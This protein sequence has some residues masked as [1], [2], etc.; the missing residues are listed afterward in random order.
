MSRLKDV[1]TPRLQNFIEFQKDPLFSFLNML[2]KGDIVS[3]RT[4]FKP[5]FIVN[6]PEFVKEILV[7]KDSFFRKGRTT[8][9]LR[10]TIGDGLLTTEKEEHRRQKNYYQPIFYKERLNHYAMTMVEETKKL[11]ETLHHRKNCN[12]SDEMMQL[13]LVIISKVM[14]AT[15]LEKNKELLAKAVSETIEQT[16]HTL[17]SPVILPLNVPTKRHKIHKKAICKLE[18]MIYEIIKQ[19][20]E[21]PEN[22]QKTMV[23]MMLDT[24]LATGERISD[25]EIRN[26]MMTM[27]LAGHETSANL[28]TW[29]FYALS[30]NPEVERKFHEEIDAISLLEESPFEVYSKLAYTQQMMKEALR[31][32]HLLGL[33]TERQIKMWSY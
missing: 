19:A 14:F 16:A 22:Y 11:V 31:C 15:D 20:K 1:T 30:Q 9:V 3:L 33:Y 18:N 21:N 28:L 23:G 13:T 25:E 26:Q 17:L 2:D 29:I 10:R 7:T 4:G 27:L 24:T 12:L 8:K 32:F 5:S 6:S